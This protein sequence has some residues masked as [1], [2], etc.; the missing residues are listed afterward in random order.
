MYQKVYQELAACVEARQGCLDN[1]NWVWFVIWSDKI[2][3]I[4]DEHLLHGS[5]FD[6]GTMID[7]D[8]ST[9][10]KLVFT[11]A[12]HTMDENGYYGPWISFTVTVHPSLY[13]NFY[14]TVKG[15]FGSKYQDLKDH[16]ADTF[17]EYLRGDVNI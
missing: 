9:G 6:N 7:L 14:L 16:V 2:K 4:T 5:G 13:L 3:R 1:D 12:F 11:S 10:D 8:R 17:S 15:R